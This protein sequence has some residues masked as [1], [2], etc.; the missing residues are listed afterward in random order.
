MTEPTT[1]SGQI[2]RSYRDSTPWWPEPTRAPAGSPNIVFIVLD[3]VG[4]AHLGCYGSDISTPHMDRLAAGGL[5]Y[6]NFHTTAMC[7]PTRASLLSGRQHHAAGVG[8]VA[9]FAVGFPGYQGALTKRAATLAEMIGPKGYSTLAVGKWHLMPLRHAS[10]AGPFDYWPTQRGFDHWY[11]FAGGY[12]DSWHPE[13]YDGTTAVDLPG[14]PGYHLSEDLVDRAI[15]QVRD[16]QSA[17]QDRPFFLY[18]AFGAAHWPHHVPL[19]YVEKYR[20]RYDQGWDVAREAWLARQKEMGIVP[21][22]TVLAPSDPEVPAWDTL[23][24]DEQRLAARHMEVYAGFLEHTDAQIGRLID[25]LEAIGQ[26]D[27]TLVMLISDNGASPEGGRLGCVNVDLQYQAGVQE[28]TEIGLAAL[29]HLG[30]ETTNPHY[31]TGWAQ[32]GCTPLKWYKM[33]TH[34]GGVRDPLIVHWPARIKDGGSLRH[35]YHHVVDIVPT[36]LELLGVEAPAEVNGI[37]QLPIHGTSLAYS[38]DHPDEPTHKQT[39]YYEMLGDRGIWHQGWKAVTHHAAGTD[40]EADRWE[41]YHLDSDY[42]EIDD[43]AAEQPERLRQLVERWWAEAGLHNVL[44]LDDRRGDRTATGGHPNPRR[45]FV[46][47]PG[48]A[49]VERWN[50]P[51]VTNRSFSIAA[52]VEIPN[53]GAEGVLLAVGNRFGGYTLFVKAGRLTFEYNAG[54]ARYAVT[55]GAKLAAGR[56]ALSMAFV[57]TGRLQGRA[58]L[59]IDGVEAGSV[60]CPRTWAINPARSSLYCGRDIGAPVSDAYRSPFT[61]TGT[62]HTVTV[63]LEDDQARDAAAERRAAIAED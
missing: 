46:Y 11:G 34:G 54:E 21:P 24:A 6:T 45:T 62:I 55:S 23:D 49:R 4:F 13:L 61:F 7:S 39:Q 29:D 41:L 51:N 5:R 14:T 59:S 56:H 37:P 12:T 27:N 16:Q 60:E 35:Q 2:G 63:T 18:V 52:D 48:M 47:R 32:A 31:P 43:L 44:P 22:A 30:D 33:D 38:L 50:A 28:S 25:Y 19:S 53:D 17:G 10:A 42:S 36:I 15:V 8:A 20:G 1:F 26:L 9:E 3:D 58:T 57:K 40:F